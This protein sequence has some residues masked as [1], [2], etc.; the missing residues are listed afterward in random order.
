MGM[1]TH[2]HISSNCE[3][4]T[5]LLGMFLLMHRAQR[6]PGADRSRNGTVGIKHGYFSAWISRSELALPYQYVYGQCQISKYM[7]NKW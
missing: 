1:L 6:H 5:M 3:R 4:H 7:V 2:K